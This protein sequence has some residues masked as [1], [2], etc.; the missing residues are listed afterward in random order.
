MIVENIISI[1]DYYQLKDHRRLISV[2]INEKQ[3]KELFGDKKIMISNVFEK[4]KGELS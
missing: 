4:N 2:I 1:Q 3:S